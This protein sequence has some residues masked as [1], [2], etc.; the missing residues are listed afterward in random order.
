MHTAHNYTCRTGACLTNRASAVT[1]RTRISCN[2]KIELL[3]TILQTI[4]PV[5]LAHEKPFGHA[6]ETEHG[7]VH[8]TAPVEM[9]Q[10]FPAG[11]LPLL[12]LHGSVQTTAPVISEQ[13]CPLS[14]PPLLVAQEKGL[15]T[16]IGGEVV[17]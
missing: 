11:Q 2:L 10:V 4:L 14:Q 5:L 15:Q 17:P 13:V 12:L 6:V 16:L 9:E 1:N 3:K 7:S 8:T